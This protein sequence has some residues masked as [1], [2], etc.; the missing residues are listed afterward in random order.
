MFDLQAVDLSQD[1]LFPTRSVYG[2]ILS[3]LRF[4][5]DQAKVDAICAPYKYGLVNWLV[6]KLI[7]T[8][9]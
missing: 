5:L 4:R 8:I 9:G 6:G 2:N 7:A 3:F 1:T